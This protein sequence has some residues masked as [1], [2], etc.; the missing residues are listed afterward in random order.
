M[1]NKWTLFVKGYVSVE[2]RGKGIERLLNDCNRNGLFLWE[3]KRK[4]E[5][6]VVCNMLL[7][8]VYKLKRIRRNHQ[9]QLFF[10]K[11]KGL[12]FLFKYSIRNSGIVIGVLSFFM[13]IFI[14][15]NMV[16]GIEI[17]GAK[18]ETEALIR[19]ELDHLGVKVGK[20]QF[21]LV[22][23]ESIQRYL[24]NNVAS[25]TWVG[26]ELKGTTFQFKVVE[27]NEP[28][29]EK[30]LSARNLVASK[31][32]I[33]TKLYVE[34]GKPVVAINDHVKKGQLLVSG[35]IGEGGKT[36][37]VP[38]KG[39]VYGETW[40]ETVVSVPLQSTFSTLTEKQQTKHY[41]KIGKT[42]IKFFGFAQDKYKDSEVETNTYQ[43]HFL[44]WKLPLYYI[45]VTQKEKVSQKRTYNEKEALQVAEEISKKNL[46]KIINK[47]AKI[48][49]GTVLKQ[50]VSS[51]NELVV[52]YH[53]KVIENIAQPQGITSA[54]NV[55]DDEAN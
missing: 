10:K 42:K 24:T 6:I 3:V 5:D 2:I 43:V 51:S 22:D 19:K 7:E 1:K 41:G 53:Y 50:H 40:Y 12:P 16:L 35:I 9:C 34:T 8:D 52:H 33:I 21:S 30:T 25:I 20:L 18:P 28:K 31:E 48:L 39:I 45:K 44:H 13:L 23:I 4:Q 29:Q 49:E 55:E 38:A 11:R 17:K 54:P 47:H 37:L 27:K 15:S 36:A 14:F 26:V 32:A 46:K